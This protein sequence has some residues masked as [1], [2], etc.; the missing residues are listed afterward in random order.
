[1][2]SILGDGKFLYEI[3]VLFNKHRLREHNRDKGYKINYRYEL[4][5]YSKRLKRNKVV[6]ESRVTGGTDDFTRQLDFRKHGYD[7][8]NKLYALGTH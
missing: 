4:I 8:E 6:P 7:F 3:Q 2:W 5:S 1:M